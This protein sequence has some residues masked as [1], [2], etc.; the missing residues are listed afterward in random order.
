M[1]IEIEKEFIAAK[2]AKRS[3]RNGG[4]AS[5]KAE[6]GRTTKRSKKS[7]PSEEEED[8]DAMDIDE[9]TDSVDPE[10]NEDQNNRVHDLPQ[11][12]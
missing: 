7:V 9:P 8:D 11:Q 6:T 1:S 12:I 10:P 3:K 5:K 2:T 4:A